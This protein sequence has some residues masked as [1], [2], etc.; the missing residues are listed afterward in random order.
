[1]AAVVEMVKVTAESP[2][3]E[4]T[5]AGLKAHVVSAG[6]LEQLKLTLLGNV[7]VVGETSRLY[8]AVCFPADT[9]TLGGVAFKVKSKLCTGRA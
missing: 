1:M 4:G 9:D 2:L 5:C 8:T 3:P 6:S 7:S